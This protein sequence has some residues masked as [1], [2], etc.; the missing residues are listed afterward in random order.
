MKK[1]TST[2]EKLTSFSS[3]DAD[4]IRA[5]AAQLGSNYKTL[6][7]A[8]LQQMINSSMDTLLVARESE[9]MKIVGIVMFVSYRIFYLKKAYIDD[10]IVDAAY[11]GQGIGSELLMKAVDLAK[12][13]GAAYVDFTSHPTRTEG[14]SLYKKLGFKKREANGYRLAFDYGKK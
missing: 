4:A 7:D 5:L 11:R 8:D 6:S 10:L 13:T 12:E 1:N 2:I 9:Q 3:Q 14:N